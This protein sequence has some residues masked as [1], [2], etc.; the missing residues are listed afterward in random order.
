MLY[1][2][3]PYK[4]VNTFMLTSQGQR[5][6]LHAIKVLLQFFPSKLCQYFVVLI[7]CHTSKDRPEWFSTFIHDPL[8][9]T[10]G[11]V[12]FLV[13]HGEPV[14]CQDAPKLPNFNLN[15]FSPIEMNS[16]VFFCLGNS[17]MFYYTFMSDS[18]S[19]SIVFSS[20]TM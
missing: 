11:C 16:P 7:H 15:V 4:A 18:S 10:P 8:F 13:V 19:C 14:F 17:F 12:F 3:N 2:Q 20:Y 1:F 9:D 5:T 6:D